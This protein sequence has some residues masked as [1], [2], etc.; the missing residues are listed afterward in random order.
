MATV[1]TVY[2]I[3]T[4]P[5]TPEEVIESLFGN[6]TR[7]KQKERPRPKN[8]ELFASLPQRQGVDESSSTELVFNWLELQARQRNPDSGKPNVIIMDGQPSLWE[9]RNIFFPGSDVIEILDLLHVTPRL[10]TAAHLFHPEGSAEAVG[11]VRSY[12]H[13]VLQGEVERAIANLKQL[14]KSRNLKGVKKRSLDTICKY[15]KKNKNRM[16]YGEYLRKGYPIASGVIEGA[17]RHLIKDRMERAG[18]R[19]SE[20]GAQAMLD[21]RS[22]HLNGDWDNFMKFR[23]TE[24]TK[25]IHPHL[26][27]VR[28]VNWPLAA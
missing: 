2:T 5:R 11:F 6:S 18:M 20:T 4:S 17:C 3:E 10:W 1:G 24:Q 7:D 15:M 13:I 22:V 19:W 23:I 27:M 25:K 16:R 8:K 9:T 26:K 21:L 12:L 28:Q 14:G